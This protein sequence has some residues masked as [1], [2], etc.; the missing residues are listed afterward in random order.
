MNPDLYLRVREKEGRVYTDDIVRHLP[1]VPDGHPLADEWK[2]RSASASRLRRYLARFSRRLSILDIGCGNGWLANVLSNSGHS[3]V[4]IDQNIHELKQA[5]RVFSRNT[6]VI[7]TQADV[8]SAPFE[9]ESFDIVILASSIQY[10][11]DLHILFR[12]LCKYLRGPGEIHVLDS[13][14]YLDQDV[15]SAMERSRE[16]YAALGFPDMA[17]R[18]FHHRLS[19]LEVFRPRVIYQPN[20]KVLKIKH[21]LKR[22]DSPFPWLSIQK[23]NIS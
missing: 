6:D 9:R 12:T 23:Q 16:Y 1:V 18:Y 2:A 11:S 3:V 13:P 19:D 8:F 20:H 22:V 15:E 5:A 4:G 7:F 10:F 14:L 21:F 17:D